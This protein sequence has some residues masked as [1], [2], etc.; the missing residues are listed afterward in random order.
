MSV[1]RYLAAGIRL[2]NGVD[3][4]L[5]QPELDVLVRRSLTSGAPHDAAVHLEDVQVVVGR[6]SVS[7]MLTRPPPVATTNR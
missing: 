5:G 2:H 1:R 7:S 3:H 4:A 6:H